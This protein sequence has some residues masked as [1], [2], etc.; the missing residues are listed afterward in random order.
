MW[1][2]LAKMF[3][4]QKH[5]E[6]S[7]FLGL[8]VFESGFWGIESSLRGE[9]LVIVACTLQYNVFRWLDLMPS[10]YLTKG[11]WE[12]PCPL[13]VSTENEDS[14]SR[15]SIATIHSQ[16]LDLR[17]VS[18]SCHVE[19]SFRY[20]RGSMKESRNWN[21][22][23]IL[24]LRNERFD[25]QKTTLKVYLMFWI[26]NMFNLF[27]L[28]INMIVLLLASFVFL[29][30]ISLLYISFLA[31]FILLN[32]RIIRK[33]WPIL[34]FLFACVLILEYFAI[35]KNQFSL[36]LNSQ[37]ESNLRC[38]DCWKSSKVHLLY[39]ECCWLGLIVDDPRTLM[40]YFIVFIVACF[41]L[42]ADKS[43]SLS[44]SFTYHQMMSQ[45]KNN[46]VWKD[47]S[48]ETKS[49]WTIFDYLRLYCYCHLLDL[50][51]TSILVTGTLEYDIL[52]LGYLGF[53]VVFFRLRL[54]ILRNRNKIFKFLRMYN[55][56]IIVL[57]LAYQSP[58]VGVFNEGK[59][60]TV[61]YIYEVIGFY[62]Y[63][64]GFRITSRS[65]LVEIVIFILVSVQSYMFSSP[66]FEHV[67]RYLEAEQ[68]GAIVREQEKKATWKTAQLQHIRESEELKHQRNLQVEKMKSEMLDLQVQL[69]SM[70]SPHNRDQVSPGSGSLRRRS[71]SFNLDR[72]VR[73][74]QKEDLLCPSF[75]FKRDINET[76]KEETSLR[77]GQ[78]GSSDFIL[79]SE[80]LGSPVSRGS[81]SP[82]TEESTRH[83]L[84]DFYFGEISVVEEDTTHSID[85]WKKESSKS[86]S[87]EHPLKSAAQL[88]GDGVSQVQSLGNQAV[89]NLA[90]L[91]NVAQDGNPNG[92]SSDDDAR[93][94]EVESQ[95]VEKKHLAR[96]SS[97]Q[98]D[99]SKT[100]SESV[101]TQLERIC[102]HIWSQMRSNN[103]I[104]ASFSFSFGAS[105]YFL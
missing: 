30:V 35:W 17:R 34:V 45:R 65:A 4:G 1:G 99:T 43:P 25:M 2:Q 21:K 27:G 89:N 100:M 56:A 82:T 84:K 94:D 7:L 79:P 39:C 33:L 52:H 87:K 36:V 64:Y 80:K 90:N 93:L 44:G 105:V 98:S 58:F 11:E 78:K 55:F 72:D 53:A 91:L 66:E 77:E 62:K 10:S 103:D 61:G 68:I 40:S 86:G 88:I 41:K 95:N 101:R 48:F 20:F 75:T 71:A 14:K 69:H 104:V 6:L 42:R 16:P 37:T 76:D 18:N 38:H 22:K 13:F 96:T 8:H 3:P 49:M 19:S 24:A 92:H 23:R 51:L 59:C 97:L 85:E 74:F 67:S 15:P 29:N 31:I 47:L 57:S 9:V 70:N 50:V 26:E 54:E 73:A 12:E 60:G 5:S 32:R 63:D 28:E 102:Q 46:F 83:D 81:I